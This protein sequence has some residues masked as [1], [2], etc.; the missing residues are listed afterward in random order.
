MFI[1]TKW[2]FCINACVMGKITGKIHQAVE[3]VIRVKKCCTFTYQ[4][5]KNNNSHCSSSKRSY[6]LLMNQLNEY[7][8][9]KTSKLTTE[10]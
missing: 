3:N 2:F 7:E 8:K 10:S 4:K 9:E 1:S 5:D 6:N